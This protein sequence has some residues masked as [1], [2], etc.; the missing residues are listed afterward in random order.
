GIVTAFPDAIGN[1]GNMII[2][3][4]ILQGIGNSTGEKGIGIGITTRMW[5]IETK[6]SKKS[7]IHQQP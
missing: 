4:N 6:K 1:C 2:R 7:T 3:G 5:S